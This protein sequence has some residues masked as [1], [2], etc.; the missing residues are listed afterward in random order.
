M[1]ATESSVESQSLIQTFSIE[2]PC[3]IEK[4]YAPL[5]I[6]ILDG[7]SAD[8]PRKYCQFSCLSLYLHPLSPTNCLGKPDV[9]S[10]SHT[11]STSPHLLHPNH[12]CTVISHSPIPPDWLSC[13]LWI[14]VLNTQ[15][16]QLKWN[17][18]H[19]WKTVQKDDWTEKDVSHWGCIMQLQVVTYVGGIVARWCRCGRSEA[20]VIM[21]P[22]LML[23]MEGITRRVYGFWWLGTD[24]IDDIQ[25]WRSWCRSVLVWVVCALCEV[26]KSNWA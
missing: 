14:V 13:I 5:F 20:A 3:A 26:S 10:P 15:K 4:P 22:G 8:E 1:F 24:V 6:C 25:R 17:Y 9:I 2:G 19:E 11:N 16:W 7:N 21:T 23:W 18:T 12:Y